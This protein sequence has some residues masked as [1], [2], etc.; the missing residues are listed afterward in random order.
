MLDQDQPLSTIPTGLSRSASYQTDNSINCHPHPH[1][2]SYVPLLAPGNKRPCLLP[3]KQIV[4]MPPW[5]IDIGRTTLEQKQKC[6]LRLAD[7]FQALSEFLISSCSTYNKK[8]GVYLCVSK[9]MHLLH[10]QFPP[11]DFCHYLSRSVACKTVKVRL[12]IQVLR[13]LLK[14]LQSNNR[15]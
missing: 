9:K 5:H 1:T 7:V 15:H 8:E 10:L 2:T 4:P 11:P 12:H 3:M 13:G 14:G 6:W